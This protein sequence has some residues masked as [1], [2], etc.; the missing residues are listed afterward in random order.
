MFD[1]ILKKGRVLDG[2]GNPW[3]K[4]DVAIKDGRIAKI[5]RLDEKADR[6][7]DYEFHRI[8]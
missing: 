4:A 6:V 1:L 2:A 3:F 5:G 8:M 7:I